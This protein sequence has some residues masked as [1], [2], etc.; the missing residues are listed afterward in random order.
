MARRHLPDTNIARHPIKGNF[1]AVRQRLIRYPIF[2]MAVSSVTEGELPW[3]SDARRQYGALRAT[4]QQGG[5][6]MGNPG[7]MIGAHALAAG[8]A[9]P[10]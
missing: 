3:D 4:L 8:R 5:Q 9:S 1:R 2:E 6:A 7:I 10:D